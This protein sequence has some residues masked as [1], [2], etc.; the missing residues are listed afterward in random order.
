MEMSAACRAEQ[1]HRSWRRPFRWWRWGLWILAAT[2]LTACSQLAVATPRPT[3]ITIAGATAMHPVLRALTAA[4]NQQHPS[5]LFVIRGGGSTL[6]EQQVASGQV[7]LAASTLWPAQESPG[8]GSSPRPASRLTRIPIGLDGI[9]VVVHPSNR[10]EGLTMTQL[11][12]IYSGRILDW[13]EV[14]GT[15]GDI[16]LVSREDGSGTRRA[17]EERVMGDEPVSLTAV[18]MPTSQDVVEFV[19][20]TPQAIG[21]VSLAYVPAPGEPGSG[22]PEAVETPTP[23]TLRPLRVLPIDGVWPTPTSLRDQSY[24]LLQP[25]YLV[26]RGEPRGNVRQFVDF[27]L[28]PAGQEIVGRFHLPVR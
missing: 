1:R 26:S 17:F 10:V 27:V 12:E 21:Y 22:T 24:P 11:Q 19:A 20:K 2:T 23:A 14:G 7:D 15:P 25:L 8:N 13:Q 18:V 16:L 5:T 9:A 6:G 4:F 3:T 28:S